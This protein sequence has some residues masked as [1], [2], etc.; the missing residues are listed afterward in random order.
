MGRKNAGAGSGN[1][2]IAATYCGPD[3]DLTD[4][5]VLFHEESVH[6]GRKLSGETHHLSLFLSTR[7]ESGTERDNK[8]ETSFTLSMMTQVYV[9]SSV[10]GIFRTDAS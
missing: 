1:N 6:L 2:W 8:E 3:S 9:R 5:L 4:I 10:P 7:E